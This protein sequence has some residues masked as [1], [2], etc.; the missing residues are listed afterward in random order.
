MAKSGDAR[1][2]PILA[3]VEPT[4]RP[5]MVKALEMGATDILPRPIDPEELSARVRTQIRRKRYTDFLRQKLDSS[6]EW[7]SPTP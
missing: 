2:A 7:P 5:R 6:L 1:R 4:E 3:V